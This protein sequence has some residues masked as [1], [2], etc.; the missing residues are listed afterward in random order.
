MTEEKRTSK[1]CADETQKPVLRTTA[2]LLFAL[3]LVGFIMTLPT[4]IAGG[5]A[6]WTEFT[7]NYPTI[8]VFLLS[9]LGVL[10]SL[11]FMI[12]VFTKSC[13]KK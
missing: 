5:S 9:A 4:I 3:A 2:F 11:I 6:Y 12:P 10:A 13:D 1:L 8:I 7:T